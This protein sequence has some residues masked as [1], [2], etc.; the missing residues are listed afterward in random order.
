MGDQ[1]GLKINEDG[2]TEW[3]TWDQ[4]DSLPVLQEGVGGTVDAVG[5]T[6]DVDMWL[7][8]EGLFRY[9][10]NPTATRL[11]RLHDKTHQPYYGPVIITGQHDGVTLGLTR[12][13]QAWL[14]AWVAGRCTAI[15]EREGEAAHCGSDYSHPGRT[16]Q[17]IVRGERWIWHGQ[18]THTLAEITG[19]LQ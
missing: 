17:S 14:T 15:D 19:A 12:E 13:A 2:T 18:P 5:L 16:H 1:I 7:H 9:G 3:V 10:V 6:E 8:D 11:A 4:G